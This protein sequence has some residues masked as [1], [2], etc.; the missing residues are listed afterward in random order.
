MPPRVNQLARQLLRNPVTISIALSKPAEG[1]KQGVYLVGDEH[2]VAL[3]TALLRDTAGQRI[4]VFCST[5]SAVSKLYQKLKTRGL[6]VGIISSDLEQDQREQV[7]LAFR[8]RQIDILVATD[9]VSRGIDVEGIDMVIN[10]DVPRD[11]E[12]YVHR[13]GRTGRAERKGEA[14]TLVS[15]ADMHRLKRIEKLIGK[16]VEKYELPA[17]FKTSSS[18]SS[19]S[20]SATGHHRKTEGGD[21]RR[22]R[23]QRPSGPGKPADATRADNGQ[24]ATS[25]RPPQAERPVGEG[26]DIKKRRKRGGRRRGGRGQAGPAIEGTAAD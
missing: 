22:R 8:N 15:P 19:S 7:M 20:S 26:G 1:V 11:A 25:P 18:G 6:N 21:S 4:L 3:I 10:Y 17:Q 12:D 14:L 16:E 23:G 5:K 2:K 24:A 9:V 13:I